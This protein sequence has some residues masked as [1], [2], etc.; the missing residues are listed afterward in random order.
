MRIYDPRLGRFLSV[1]PLTKSY[2]WYTPYSFAGNNPIAFI[3][4]DGAEP[5]LNQNNGGDRA[6]YLTITT[7]F[8]IRNSITNTVIR[9]NPTL[10]KLATVK[11]LQKGGISDKTMQAELL[12]NY[13]ARMITIVEDVGQDNMGNILQET[14]REWALT[15]KN[16]A[17]KEF[18]AAAMDVVTIASTGPSKGAPL[19]FAKGA[20]AVSISQLK[21]SFSLLYNV[22]RLSSVGID[23]ALSGVHAL[24]DVMEAGMAFVGKNSKKMYTKGGRFE[25]WESA[26]GLKRFRPATYKKNQNKIQS[27]FEQRTSSDVKWDDA[28][29]SNMHVNTDKGFDFR[30]EN[31]TTGSGN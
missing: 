4:L 23:N 26:D 21:K 6:A 9:L 11:L 15:A 10:E 7:I 24:E 20:Q 29:K 2:P 14:R 3:D 12:N 19:L 5:A 22:R 25:G 17:G 28:N 18:L 30:K 31:K 27:N 8:D 13:V 16:S 1:D